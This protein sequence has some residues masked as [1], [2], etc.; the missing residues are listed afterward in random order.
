MSDT[1]MRRALCPETDPE[2]FYLQENRHEEQY[3]EALKICRKCPVRQPCL[4][5][6]FRTGDKWAVLG[7][8]TPRQRSRIR[9]DH[10]RQ[11]GVGAAV[12]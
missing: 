4:A 8:T 2:L 9:R 3:A 5:W 6:A 12:L 7:G 1:W 11:Q 10:D